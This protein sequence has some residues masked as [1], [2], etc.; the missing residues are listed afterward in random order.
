MSQCIV[1]LACSF[2]NPSFSYSYFRWSAPEGRKAENR[3]SF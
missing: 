3:F 1:F 2:S